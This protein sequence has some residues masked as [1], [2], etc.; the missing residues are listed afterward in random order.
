MREETHLTPRKRSMRSKVEVRMRAESSKTLKEIGRGKK[1]MTGEERLMYS[2]RRAKRKVALLLQ[3]LEK[4]ELPELPPP[5]HDPG[6]P[7]PEQLP[8]YKK[9]G[10][11]NRYYVPVGVRGVFGGVVRN[12]HMHWK[13]H[14]TVQICC[15]NF[16][17]RWQPCLQ[18]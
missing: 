10:F 14:E 1:L 7:T 17:R 13:F 4:Y 8:A 15:D 5:K 6:L 3:K 12:M 16:P 11:R 18:D 9:I 2:L